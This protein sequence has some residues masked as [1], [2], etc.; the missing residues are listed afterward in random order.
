M[1][2]REAMRARGAGIAALALCAALEVARAAELPEAEARAC[3]AALVAEDGETARAALARVE[4]ARDRRF[5]APLVELLRAAEV[6]IASPGAAAASAETLAVL[7]GERF[8]DDWPAWV[9]WYADSAL[10]PPPGFL[11]WK[12]ALFA[13]KDPRFSALLREGTPTRVRV[14]EIVWGGVAYE[15]IPALEPVAYDAAQQARWLDEGEPVF[16]IA[17]GGEARAYPLRIL[18]WHELAN[19]TLG[20]AP[21]ALA[22]CTL[23]GTGIAYLRT[24]PDGRV[25]DF[26]SSG[27]LLRSNKLMVDR[28]TRTLW[29]QFTGRP[30]LGPLAARDLALTPIASVVARWGDW[31]STHPETTVISRATGHRRPYEPGAAYGGY[32]ASA[33][34]MFPAPRQRDELPEKAQIYGVRLDAAAKAYPL[35][36]LARARVVNDAVGATP[37]VLV[38]ARG[39]IT[40]SGESLRDGAAQWSAGAEVRAYRRGDRRFRAGGAPDELLDTDGRRWSVREDAL[41]GPAGARAERVVGVLSYWFGWAAF[42]P[43]TEVWRAP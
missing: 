15:G 36:A 12:G 23:C 14:E 24:L 34:T 3:L 10:A 25:L 11:G 35:Q 17:H 1:K 18:D 13:R 42:V 32:F 2:A 38:A 26:G 20:G 30:A 27:L 7:T 6:G 31:R 16:G 33:D 29:N 21:I 43:R 5:V 4:Q 19:D 28:Q 39:T 8:G 22:Y 9:R 37:I 41:H 40:S